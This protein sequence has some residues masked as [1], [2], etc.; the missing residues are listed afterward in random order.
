MRPRTTATLMLVAGLGAC[1]Y[2]P[3]SGSREIKEDLSVRIPR[4]WPKTTT[5]DG[6]TLQAI[7]VAADDWAPRAGPGVPCEDSQFAYVFEAFRQGDIIFVRISHGLNAQCPCSVLDGGA[8]YAIGLDG[9][10]LRRIPDGYP[11]LA[12]STRGD[13]HLPV[14][15]EMMLEDGGFILP[16]G[17]MIDGGTTWVPPWE[18][19]RDGGS[20]T[21]G[22]C[23]TPAE[24]DGGTTW[25]SP[26]EWLRDGGS[27]IDGGCL[28]EMHLVRPP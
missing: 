3:L 18:W 10:I 1:A 23:L 4:E 16:G 15:G 11:D 5:L 27:A 20:A 12:E 21:D 19:P 26:S 17:P 14:I 9:R 7:R 13:E 25:A 24:I 22:G 28:L 6:P 2:F 8:I